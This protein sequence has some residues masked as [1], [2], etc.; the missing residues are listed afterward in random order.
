MKKFV[1]SE[2]SIYGRTTDPVQN[3]VPDVPRSTSVRDTLTL[4]I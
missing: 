2:F 4:L 1:K 3:L